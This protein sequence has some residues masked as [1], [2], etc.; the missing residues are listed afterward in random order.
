MLAPAFLAQIQQRFSHEKRARVC[1]WFDPQ[2]EF[3]RLLPALQAHL[4]KSAAPAI[5]LLAYD[6]KAKHGQIWLKHQV[7]LLSQADPTAKFVLYLPLPEERWNGPDERGKHHLELLT[8]YRITGTDWKVGG[9]RPSLFSFLK[10][11]GA[12]LPTDQAEQRKLTDGGA[13]S[14]LAKYA[15]KFATKAPLFWEESL[16]AELAQ[17]RLVGDV[18][19]Q[20]LDLAVEPDTEWSA[21]QEKGVLDEFL[22]ALTERL[23]SVPQ[24]DNPVLWVKSLV[25]RLALTEA[26]VGYGEPSD[27]PFADRL[28]P[29][30]DREA[31]VALLRR[32]L[33]DTN[34]RPAWDRWIAEIEQHVNLTAW[35]K[36]KTGAAYGFPHLV[37]LRWQDAVKSVVYAATK[38]EGFGDYLAEEAPSL[39]SEA[40]FSRASTTSECDWDHLLGVTEFVANCR[41]LQSLIPE[42]GSSGECV[43]LYTDFAERVDGQHLH[44]K[45]DAAELGLTDIG[46]LLDRTYGQVANALNQRFFAFYTATDSPDIPGLPF[47]TSHLDAHLWS[48]HGRRAVVI[49]DAL[50]LDVAFRLKAQLTGFKVN[51]DPLRAMLPTRTP[52]GMSALLPAK[53]TPTSLKTTGADLHPIYAD[54]DLS[55]RENRLA[56]LKEFGADT[57]D[58]T[59]VENAKKPGKLPTLLV[60]YGHE[61]V[62]SMGHGDGETLIRHV[63]KE[64]ERLARVVRKLH[65]WGYAEVHVVTDHGFVLLDEVHLPPE[66]PFNKDWGSVNKERFAIIPASADVPIKSK[67]FAWDSSV[68]VALPPGLAYFKT[69]KSFSHGGAALQEMVIPHLISR[70]QSKQ[71]KIGVEIL[72]GGAG[73]NLSS[74]AVKIII[75]P[76]NV[77]E[78]GEMS[79]L[80]ALPRNLEINV[81]RIVGA[82]TSSV[83]PR[84]EAK[85]A[86]LKPD[87]EVPVT[88][89]F[90]SKFTLKQGDK[91]RLEIRDADTGEQFPGPEGITLHV[92]RDL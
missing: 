46:L 78:G 87:A 90:D 74:A 89:F 42:V 67:P 33:R 21:L 12:A 31:Y 4:A 84:G 43:R 45:A 22:A 66:V 40:D 44:L 62:D 35:A 85:K 11:A 80:V 61:E 32:W 23:G 92:A 29:S 26:F 58:I 3:R 71:Q 60:V 83:L 68:R 20:F 17:S 27:F 57:R 55:V 54:K 1:V 6:S 13:D 47:V 18:D 59:E 48:G 52:V 9:K 75:R 28:P 24:T 73:V 36:G 91:L 15:A 76:V 69:E 16:T 53:F 14:P 50:R 39:R 64:L 41:K 5:H 7:W 86:T 10:A 8:E 2:E 37:S 65:Q 34:C 38:S 81:V 63:Q 56:L 77:G 70:Q 79:S 19:Q 82:N 49:V 30:R 72:I 25:E 51:I 88:L